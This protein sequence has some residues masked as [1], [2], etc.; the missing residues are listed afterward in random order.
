MNVEGEIFHKYKYSNE[1]I[2]LKMS[3]VYSH[4][5]ITK[6]AMS[7]YRLKN[8]SCVHIVTSVD[9]K[10]SHVYIITVTSI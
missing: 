6:K 2:G 9:L 5:Y 3:R 7:I 10:M 8:E 1:C 4:V